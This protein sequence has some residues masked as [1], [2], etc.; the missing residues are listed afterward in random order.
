MLKGC[1][2]EVI[3]L[4]RQTDKYPDTNIATIPNQKNKMAKGVY[5]L[6]AGSFK[7]A[8]RLYFRGSMTPYSIY[9]NIEFSK[10]RKPLT[11]WEW[12]YERLNKGKNSSNADIE[13]FKKDQIKKFCD[14]NIS[15]FVDFDFKRRGPHPPYL[16]NLSFFKKFRLEYVKTDDK[17]RKLYR[18]IMPG[19]YDK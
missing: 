12:E 14:E 8:E 7:Y 6:H 4:K 16:K 9:K 3:F 1:S 11:Y 13:K 5:M 19:C 18:R 10:S 2:K 15:P 17:G